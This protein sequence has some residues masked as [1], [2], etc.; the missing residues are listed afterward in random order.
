MCCAVSCRVVSC[1]VVPYRPASLDQVHSFPFTS[2]DDSSFSLTFEER[3]EPGLIA[4]VRLLIHDF[5][6]LRA[7]RKGKLPMTAMDAK[8][9]EVLQ[10]VIAE[11]DGRYSQTIQVGLGSPMIISAHPMKK[12]HSHFSR[13]TQRK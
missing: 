12:P 2:A 3:I 9:G 5:E 8:V 4:F 11:R 10:V 7:K 1:R 6:W 13:A